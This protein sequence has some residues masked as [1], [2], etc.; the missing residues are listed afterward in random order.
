M[1]FRFRK[2]VS[3]GPVR[4]NLSKSGIGYS[5]GAKGARITKKANGGTRTTLSV[6]GT[7]ISHVSGSK[8]RKA[9]TKVAKPKKEKKVLTP[10]EKAAAEQKWKQ[11]NATVEPF[12][13]WLSA[14]TCVPIILGG[15]LIT[16]AEPVFGVLFI[17]IG[18]LEFN[19]AKKY[20][21]KGSK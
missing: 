21:K 1:G 14:I 2:S 11:M 10:E 20:F 6:P 7:G 16:L 8:K 5:V 3:F 19:Y 18:I 4:V 9:S 13:G 17:G 15:A 12:A